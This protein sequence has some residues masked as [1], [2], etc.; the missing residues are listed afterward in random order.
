[1]TAQNTPLP[2]GRDPLPGRAGAGGGQAIRDYLNPAYP[3]ALCDEAER[4]DRLAHFAQPAPT[5]DGGVPH[6]AAIVIAVGLLA[7]AAIIAATLGV[8]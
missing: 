3:P 4:A 1:M 8:V 7:L 6:G 5:Q 2:S